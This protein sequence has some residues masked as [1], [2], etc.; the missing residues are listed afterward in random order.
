MT[1]RL[2]ATTP[3]GLINMLSVLGSACL[4][5]GKFRLEEAHPC[6]TL[7]H[8]VGERKRERTHGVILSVIAWLNAPL[9]SCPPP[10]RHLPARTKK[11]QLA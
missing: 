10:R 2:D 3:H 5:G 8:V 6:C 9:A 7:A 11:L 4:V 1:Q